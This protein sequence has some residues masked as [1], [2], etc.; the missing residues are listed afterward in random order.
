LYAML[1]G[2][3]ASTVLIPKWLSQQAALKYCAI[4][5]FILIMAAYFT[6]GRVSIYCLIATGFGAALLWGVIWGLAIRNLNKFTK[7]G[8][9]LLLMSVIGGG[10]F[11][12]LFGSMIDWNPASPQA[13][14]LVLIPCYSY[15][16][17][18]A[19]WGW[20]KNEWKSS[21]ATSKNTPAYP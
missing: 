16:F 5:G 21:P 19:V 3:V 6:T 20:K 9:A 15:L 13:A 14:V 11:P 17:Y 10:I 18:Y 2:Y 12:L 4:S 1:V 8:A 7:M